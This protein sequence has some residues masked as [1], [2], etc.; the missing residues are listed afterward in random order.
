MNCDRIAEKASDPALA[1]AFKKLAEQWRRSAKLHQQE[2]ELISKDAALLFQ[3]EP[4][5]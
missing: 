3:T 4:K 1:K 5:I 2:E